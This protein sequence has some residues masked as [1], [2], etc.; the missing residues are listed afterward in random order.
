[1]ESVRYKSFFFTYTSDFCDNMEIWR[2]LGRLFSCYVFISEVF[3]SIFIWVI[4]GL[5]KA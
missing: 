1:M 2:M 4:V 3:E 5:Y